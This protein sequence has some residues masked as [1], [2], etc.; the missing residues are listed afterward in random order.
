[1]CTSSKPSC[2]QGEE[3]AVQCNILFVVLQALARRMRD[4]QQCR[5]GAKMQ[6]GRAMHLC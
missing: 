3:A 4:L 6:S 2:L 1:M 5:C